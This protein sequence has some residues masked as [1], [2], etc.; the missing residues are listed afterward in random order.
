MISEPSVTAVRRWDD[1]FAAISLVLTIVLIVAVWIRTD[2]PDV[3]PLHQPAHTR[4]IAYWLANISFTLTLWAARLSML[5][6]LIRIIPVQFRLHQLAKWS[7]G[8][9]VAFVIA[10][11][12]Q[13][14]PRCI[15]T[16][17]QWTVLAKPQCHLGIDVGILELCTDIVGDIILIIIPLRLLWGLSVSRTRYRLLMAIFCASVFT[18]IVSVIHGVFVLGPSGLLEAITANVEAAVSVIVSNLA[19]LVTAI[20]RLF[21]LNKADD[22]LFLTGQYH[23]RTSSDEGGASSRRNPRGRWYSTNSNGD[24]AHRLRLGLGSGLQFWKGDRSQNGSIE[25]IGGTR[26]NWGGRAGGGDEWGSRR[27][28]AVTVTVDMEVDTDR[29]DTVLLGPIRPR[30]ERVDVE[31]VDE[32]EGHG[33][34]V[35][36]GTGFDAK[37]RVGHEEEGWTPVTAFEGTRLKKDDE[38]PPSPLSDDGRT[39]R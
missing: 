31:D 10:L 28:P 3:G 25:T 19:L 23:P 7:A 32:E 37:E 13:K 22:E 38:A 17:P 20:Y 16:A 35:K 15:R 34:D 24:N 11:L 2:T 12:A 9:F 21:G 4:I 26:L 27:P 39:D 1:A 8:L 36:R 29:R 33:D 6:A 5:T 14:I 18:T 30:R